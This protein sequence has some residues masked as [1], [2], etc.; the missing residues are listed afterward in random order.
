MTGPVVVDHIPP[1]LEAEDRPCGGRGIIVLMTIIAVVMLGGGLLL[2][3][4]G[5][6]SPA[7]PNDVVESDLPASDAW[8]EASVEEYYAANKGRWNRP[9]EFPEN[10]GIPEE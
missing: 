1:L 5:S 10:L 8:S 6:E 3:T 7:Q 2:L 4:K 9:L